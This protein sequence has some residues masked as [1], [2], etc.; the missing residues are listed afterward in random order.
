MRRTKRRK[1]QKC[2][3]III[4]TPVRRTKRQTYQQLHFQKFWDSCAENKTSDI[5]PNALSE[6]LERWLAEQDVGHLEHCTFRNYGTLA[7]R[8]KRRKSQQNNLLDCLSLSGRQADGRADGRADRR[9]GGR[10][11]G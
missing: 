1:Y 11:G 4:G 2:T 8:T 5:S 9:T 10:T 6:I 7:R 3:F